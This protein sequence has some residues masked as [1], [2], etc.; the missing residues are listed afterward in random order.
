M[1]IV[2]DKIDDPDLMTELVRAGSNLRRTIEMVRWRVVSPPEVAA[3]RHWCGGR[4][5]YAARLA[6]A[7]L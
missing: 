2:G 4:P 7:L 5:R 1:M 6:E 3:L